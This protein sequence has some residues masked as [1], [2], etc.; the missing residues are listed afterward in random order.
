MPSVYAEDTIEFE[1]IDGFDELSIEIGNDRVQS[2]IEYVPVVFG[3]EWTTSK[4]I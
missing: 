3:I 2:D 1:Q 4:Q